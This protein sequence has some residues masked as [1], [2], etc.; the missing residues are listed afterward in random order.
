MVFA[1]SQQSIVISLVLAR[2]LCQRE[3]L[4][5]SRPSPLAHFSTQ[6]TITCESCDCG[7]KSFAVSWH[8][9]ETGNA[10]KNNLSKSSHSA[11]DHRFSGCHGFQNR[12]SETF[13]Q[14]G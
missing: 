2:H 10:V 11:R 3:V 1:S 7:R 4:L 5:Q 6:G 13:K 12:H 8:H 14:R 9:Q